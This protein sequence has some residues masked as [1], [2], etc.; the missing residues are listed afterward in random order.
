MDEHVGGRQQVHHVGAMTDEVHT[1]RDLVPNCVRFQLAAVRPV[2]DHDQMR[3]GEVSDCLD[4]VLDPL[5][6]SQ[7]GTADEHLRVR[8]EVESIPRRVSI[9][10]A[11]CRGQLDAVGDH[12]H[13][14]GI[15]TA[16]VD[17][18]SAS[19]R[20]HGDR[21][22]GEA[23]E[24]QVLHAVASCSAP[25]L[26]VVEDVLGRHRR[27]AEALRDECAE[28]VRRFELG[29]DDP[30]R[31]GPE[32]SDE[33]TN[34]TKIHETAETVGLEVDARLGESCGEG[35]I[36]AVGQDVDANRPPTFGDRGSQSN[37]HLLGAP[38]SE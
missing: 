8:S 11:R 2:A 28:D 21:P 33:R 34:S 18:V 32:V 20:R 14:V 35:V 37:E 12:D 13:V 3:V 25:S 29:V 16:V 38:G 23:A 15:V 17:E 1:I 22:V 26:V 5:G 24:N 7:D 10:R 9:G 27:D 30:H 31:A 19:R 6:R 4:R 36:D